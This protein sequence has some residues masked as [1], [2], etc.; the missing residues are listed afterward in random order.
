MYQIFHGHDHG[1]LLQ[2]VT[3][4]ANKLQALF[5]EAHIDCVEPSQSGTVI[6]DDL[7]DKYVSDDRP[8]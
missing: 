2:V 8:L 7:G 6:I 3:A 5:G 1:K 4:S